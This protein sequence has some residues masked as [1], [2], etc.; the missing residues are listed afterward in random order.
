MEKITH[1]E[2]NYNQLKRRKYK[3]YVDRQNMYYLFIRKYYKEYIENENKYY[4][5]KKKY[6]EEYIKRKNEYSVYIKKYYEEYIK[7]YNRYYLDRKKFNDEYIKIQKKYYLSKKK[8]NENNI[9]KNELFNSIKDDDIEKNNINKYNIEKNNYDSIKYDIEES[10]LQYKKDKLNQYNKLDDKNCINI[11]EEYSKESLK[12]KY[13][14]KKNNETKIENKYEKYLEQNSGGNLEKEYK[15]CLEDKEVIEGDYN[16]ISD[17]GIYVKVPVILAETHITIPIESKIKLDEAVTEIKEIKNNIS[18]NKSR[19][20]PFSSSNIALN[21]GMLFI[22]GSIRKNIKYTTKNYTKVGTSNIYEN[23]R[24][25]TIEVPF[26]FSTRIDLI[27]LP[28]FIKET[29]PN[30]L[31]FFRDKIQRRDNCTNSV[32]G[33]NSCKE[34]FVYREVFNEE[35]FVEL[36]KATFIEVD[37][38]K[39]QILRNVPLDKEELTEI[40]EKTIVNLTLK[41]LQKQQLRVAIE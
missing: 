18:L 16:S 39:N 19:L 15:E 37:I 35:P 40:T 23:L 31:E 24:Q 28:V 22:S 41:V 34:S 25:C 21:S 3:E 8:Y 20:I 33:R 17:E 30:E 11:E 7:N 38:N 1:L 13:S 26:N 10:N 12:D 29:T 27:R 4:L 5:N 6:Y 9:T 14:L 2:E 36:V 32:F